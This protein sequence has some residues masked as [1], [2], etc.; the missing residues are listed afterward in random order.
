MHAHPRP[1]NTPEPGWGSGSKNPT[2]DAAGRSGQD[3]A[4][5]RHGRKPLLHALASVLLWGFLALALAYGVFLIVI[6]LRQ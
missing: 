6:G 2:A 1:V 3:R 4:I 5:V